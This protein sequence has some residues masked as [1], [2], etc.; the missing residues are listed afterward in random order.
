MMMM[1]VP[2]AEYVQKG[3]QKINPKFHF[4]IPNW[5]EIK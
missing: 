5:N 3:E 4:K 1:K 2:A